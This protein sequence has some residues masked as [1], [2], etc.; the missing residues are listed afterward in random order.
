MFSIFV[1]KYAYVM[2]VLLTSFERFH[3]HSQCENELQLSLLRKTSSLFRIKDQ[4]MTVEIQA[5][6]VSFTH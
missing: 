5:N 2:T 3:N 1:A 4:K 6:C